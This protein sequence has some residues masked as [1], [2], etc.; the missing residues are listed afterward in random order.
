MRGGAADSFLVRR[1]DDDIL[2]ERK[3]V[4]VMRGEESECEREGGRR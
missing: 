1:N 2:S 4:G 3:T